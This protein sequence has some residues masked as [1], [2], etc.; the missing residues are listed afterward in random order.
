MGKVFDRTAT[1]PGQNTKKLLHAG[2]VVADAKLPVQEEHGN[3]GGA[4]QVFQVTVRARDF[5][6]FKLQFVIDSLKL[7]I[8]RLQLL[9]AGLQLLRGRA[10][11]FIDGLQL[12]VGSL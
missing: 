7:L 9:L 8:D 1:V 3:L 10:E 5:V 4:H 12:F 6:K 2:R 11:L